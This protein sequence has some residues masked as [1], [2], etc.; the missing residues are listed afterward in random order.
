MK[1]ILAHILRNLSL[2]SA[3]ARASHFEVL[4]DRIAPAGLITAN[5]EGGVL[6]ITGDADTQSL[7]VTQAADGRLTLTTDIGTGLEVNGTAVQGFMGY[8]LPSLVTG[9]VSIDLGDGSDSLL[10][11]GQVSDL[12]LPGA[13]NIKSGSGNHTTTFQAGVTVGGNVKIDGGT[14]MDTIHLNDSVKMLGGLTINNGAGG[15]LLDAGKDADINVSGLLTVKSGAGFDKIDTT[16]ANTVALGGF[17]L[18]TG[19]DKDGS[20]TKLNPSGQLSIGGAVSVVNG[21]GDDDL[22]FG[23]ATL[24][25]KIKGLVNINNGEGSNHTDISGMTSLDVGGAISVKGGAGS[26]LVHVG[27][28]SG[29]V[30]LAKITV[31][32]GGGGNGTAINGETLTVNGNITV[33]GGDGT[34]QI[35]IA[36][37]KDSVITGAVKATVGEGTNSLSVTAQ[38]GSVLSI[39]KTLTYLSKGL[40]N[41]T[42]VVAIKDVKVVG[43]TSL[44]T[45]AA[46]DLVVIDDATFGG[47]FSLQTGVG[48]DTVHIEQ[49]AGS[50]GVT[51]FLGPVSIVTGADDD[52]VLAS[53]PLDPARKTIFAAS[54]KFDGGTGTN[55]LGLDLFGTSFLGSQPVKLNF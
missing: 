23:D 35:Q 1:T 45:G 28:N 34:D 20:N 3:P 11:S 15:S 13:L 16:M 6:K 27:L 5:F 24:V 8:T 50:P 54:A 39:A 51:K 44:S 29:S 14:G 36:A 2:A 30:S 47:K 22:D 38:S 25:T 7:T 40:E 17:T 37:I 49:T 41:F 10:L 42:T 31:N 19:N 53:Q 12:D 52:T 9:A 18:K 32:N 4:E 43:A 55:V 33:S 21:A 46:K 26:D 48:N